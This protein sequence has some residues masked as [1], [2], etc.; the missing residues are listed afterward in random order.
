MLCF[1]VEH[2]N[3]YNQD[4]HE[5]APIATALPLEVMPIMACREESS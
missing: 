5:V 2:Y 1:K 3:Y 4:C